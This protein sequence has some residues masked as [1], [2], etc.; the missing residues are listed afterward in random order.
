MNA[1]IAVP[2]DEG[3]IFQHFGKSAAFKIYTIENNT[4]TGQEIVETGGITHEELGIWM[5]QHSVNAVLCGNIGPGAQGA[6][7]AAGIQVLAGI[8]GGADEAV[9]LLLKGDLK[10]Q[11]SANCTCRTGNGGCG[12]NC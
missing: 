1:R 8:N 7:A 10:T 9:G 11:N 2:Y 5:L 6:L 12:G 3:N 4:V